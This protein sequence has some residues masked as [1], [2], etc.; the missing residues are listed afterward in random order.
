MIEA[1]AG[2]IKQ[3]QKGLQLFGLLEQIKL[4]P[5]IFQPVFTVSTNF[6]VNLD[7]FLLPVV[8][9]Y[10]IDGSNQKDVEIN[11]FK[12]FTDV[13]EMAAFDGK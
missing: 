3:F 2:A 12:S 1:I 8:V 9:D 7:G 13:L 6:E 10:S 4:F 5:Q 11:T